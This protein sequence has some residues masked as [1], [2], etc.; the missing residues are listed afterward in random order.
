MD[1][2]QNVCSFD[3]ENEMKFYT[4][5]G[6]NP[7]VPALFMAEKGI[8]IE[9]V[10]IDI[11]KGENRKA[12]YAALNPVAQT[13]ALVLDNGQN[14]SESVAI[15][16]YLEEIYP[17]PPLIGTT[18]EERAETRMWV[19]RV[20]LGFVQPAVHGFRGAEGLPLFKSRL[21]CVPEGAVGLKAM[22]QDGL[23]PV[24]AQLAT[25][26]YLCGNRYTLADILL[27]AFIEFAAQVGQ[28]SDPKNANISAWRARM[29]ARPSAVATANPSA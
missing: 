16:E 13:P 15:C 20:D 19:R 14:L 18:A 4:S 3:Q 29:N 10:F 22:A 8:K 24:E 21:R 12:E 23:A 28:P 1:V 27:F 9:T 5:V 11:L 7:R 17:A 6:P 2:T 26:T 25:N